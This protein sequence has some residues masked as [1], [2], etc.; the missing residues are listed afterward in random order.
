MSRFFTRLDGP[1]KAHYATGGDR[2][3]NQVSLIDCG[4]FG[5]VH[6]VWAG[7]YLQTIADIVF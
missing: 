6:R 1:N 3:L 7:H 4:G 5:E 2:K